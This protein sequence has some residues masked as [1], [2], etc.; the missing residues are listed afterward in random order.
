MAQRI[1]FFSYPRLTSLAQNVLDKKTIKKIWVIEK[2]FTELVSI[3]ESL[4]NKGMVD[5]FVS[6]G[7]NASVLSSNF[8]HMP[9]VPINVKGYD[10]IESIVKAS[11]YGPRIAV[12]TVEEQVSRLE[13]L[14]NILKVDLLQRTFSSENELARI[15]DELKLEKVDAVTGSSIVCD[16]AN[17][18]RINNVFIY[19]ETSVKE[20]LNKAVDMQ[21]V[22]INEKMKANQFK[23]I[24]D[25]AY[26]GIVAIDE[27]RKVKVFNPLAEKITGFSKNSVLEKHIDEV[28]PDTRLVRV[29]ESG[30][31]ECNQLMKV[32][33]NLVVL[34]NRIPIRVDN[35]TV[36][37]VATFQDVADIKKAERHIRMNLYQKGLIAKYTFGD[38]MG[39]SEAIDKAR[40]LARTFARE[41]S[42]ILLH[43]ETGTGKEL[44]AQSIHNH[45]LRSEKPFVVINCAALPETL[46]ESE[47][48][49]YE[50]GAFTGAK[51]GGKTGLIEL[52]N[53]GTLFLDEISE[54]PIN[55]Q[56]RFLRVLQEKEILR[57]GGDKIIPVDVRIIAATN[58]NLIQEIQKGNFREDL[59]YRLYLMY[60]K[61]PSLEEMPEDI[62][63]L[64]LKTI[65]NNYP[66]LMDKYSKTVC[67][68]ARK[69]SRLSWPGNVRQLF[70]TVH[71]IAVV[72][73]SSESREISPEEIFSRVLDNNPESAGKTIETVPEKE[74]E[75]IIQKLNET[76]WNRSRT[77]QSL[78]ISRST[79]WRKMKEYRI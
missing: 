60:I 27:N 50:E 68:V 7:S 42:T 54:M 58:R 13:K 23:A 36:G 47:L 55:L 8:P 24:I 72:L 61:V 53:E 51:K 30:E 37:V 62:P 15:M 28:I 18:Y 11:C 32:R 69:L 48:F 14:K 1:V 17:Y 57:I 44:F 34:T 78:G 66:E 76:G 19:S 4:M 67:R 31:K 22:L 26:S 63:F 56:A 40:R 43:G 64:V 52:A 33:D 2:S 16:Y 70:N 12:V 74:R 3:A 73:K 59:Y 5:V 45:S 46:L 75:L 25:F 65:E 35:R 9:L 21:E 41:D 6:A 38:I 29:L 20:A 77:A 79:L 49:G 71:R 39:Q 10:L